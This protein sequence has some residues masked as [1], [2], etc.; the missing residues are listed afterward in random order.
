MDC[1]KDFGA[2]VHKYSYIGEHKDTMTFLSSPL[3]VKRNIVLAILLRCMCVR[4]DLSG[5]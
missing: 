4:V 3:A 1:V 2:Q 5:P